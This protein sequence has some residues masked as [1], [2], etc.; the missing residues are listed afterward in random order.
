MEKKTLT[1][2]QQHFKQNMMFIVRQLQGFHQEVLDE[3]AAIAADD[4]DGLARIEELHARNSKLYGTLR[5]RVISMEAK[6]DMMRSKLEDTT[7]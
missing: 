3:V 6:N 7:A 5:E 1:P 2:K 4:P